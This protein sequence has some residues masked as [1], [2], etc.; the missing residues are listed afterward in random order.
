M[1]R[2]PCPPSVAG[3]SLIEE[4][5]TDCADAGGQITTG[6]GEPP[7]AASAKRIERSG[8]KVDEWRMLAIQSTGLLHRQVDTNCQDSWAAASLADGSCCVIAVADGA[9]S[10]ARSESG[11]AAAVDEAFRSV[12]DA[13]ADDGPPSVAGWGTVASRA[14]AAAREAIIALAADGAGF[15]EPSGD[16]RSPSSPREYA[17]TLLL[18]GVAPSQEGDTVFAA[19]LGDGAI[20]LADGGRLRSVA[21][22]ERS[23]Y[24]NEAYFVTEPDYN[25]HIATWCEHVPHLDGLAVLSDGVESLAVAER[26]TCPHPP[27]FDAIFAHVAGGGDAASVLAVLES[28]RALRTSIDDKTLVVL[29]RRLSVRS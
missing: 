7:G 3:Q 1:S 25:E 13:V 22:C 18:A 4:E 24:V 16:A 28:P 9:G 12:C 17:T 6:I 26:G 20:V 2:L 5:V 21:V 27:F 10:A 8:L 29:A 19:A 15:P 11:S 23:E 14:F